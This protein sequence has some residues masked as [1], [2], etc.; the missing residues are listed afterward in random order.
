MAGRPHCIIC[1]D[2]FDVNFRN[3]SRKKNRQ[4]VCPLKKCREAAHPVAQ[5]RYRARGGDSTGPPSAGARSRPTRAGITPP[6][7][8]LIPTDTL[9]SLIR[10]QSFQ[11]AALLIVAFQSVIAGTPEARIQ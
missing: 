6:V 7:S 8:G 4:R 2:P 11:I 10:L 1:G 5:G 3:R 9:A